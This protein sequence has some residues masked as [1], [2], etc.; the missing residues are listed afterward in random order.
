MNERASS[1]DAQIKALTSRLEKLERWK[2][3]EDKTIEVQEEWQNRLAKEVKKRKRES[4]EME[5]WGRSVAWKIV[6]IFLV[7]L[8]YAIMM[9]IGTN[10]SGSVGTTFAVVLG[11]AVV[12]FGGIVGGIIDG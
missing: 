11:V 4:K 3:R 9:E 5:A 6:P 8:F 12:F 2:R 1:R 7:A 10:E